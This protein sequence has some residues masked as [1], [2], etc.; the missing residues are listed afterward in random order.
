MSQQYLDWTLR[1]GPFYM[2]LTDLHPGNFLVDDQ[3]NIASL[4]DLEWVCARP[5]Q[6]FDIPSW[7]TS[8]S[9]DEICSPAY[10]AEYA[11]ERE[12]FMAAFNEAERDMSC[13]LSTYLEQSY[14]SKAVWFFHSL[15]SINAMYQLF[16]H[17]VRPQFIP[18]AISMKIGAYFAV[19]WSPLVGEITSRKLREREE[20]DAELRAKCQVEKDVPVEKDRAA[21]DRTG[22]N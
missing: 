16:E 2:Q 7:I 22:V 17:Q 9:L 3:W 15:D 4:V 5:P 8:R 10:K 11:A 1:H 14:T 12:K 20:Y 6:M 21:T 13:K 18:Q 19:F